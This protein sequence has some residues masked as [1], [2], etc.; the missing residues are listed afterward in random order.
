MKQHTLF[1][2]DINRYMIQRH[3]WENGKGTPQSI[4]TD[5]VRELADLYVDML[6]DSINSAAY[7]FKRHHDGSYKRIEN[8]VIHRYLL[9]AKK[10]GQN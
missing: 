9:I 6:N 2:L 10:D 3:I 4:Y 8:K 1:D 5:S 7:I